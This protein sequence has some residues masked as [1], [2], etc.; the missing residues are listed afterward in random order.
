MITSL[1]FSAFSKGLESN[2]C[3]TR[4]LTVKCDLLPRSSLEEICI[5]IQTMLP[6]HKTFSASPFL[7]MPSEAIYQSHKKTDF[8]ILYSWE[9]L[10]LSDI[11]FLHTAHFSLIISCLYETWGWRCVTETLCGSPASKMSDR[12]GIYCCN[13]RSWADTWLPFGWTSHGKMWGI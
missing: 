10:P 13:S 5:L 8:I 1:S 2:D 11:F 7:K 6:L 4:I 3:K 12:H 9:T